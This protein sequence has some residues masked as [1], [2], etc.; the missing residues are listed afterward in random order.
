MS[1]FTEMFCSPGF[2][3]VLLM[4]SLRCSLSLSLSRLPVCLI[5]FLFLVVFVSVFINLINLML[6]ELQSSCCF[7]VN[8]LLVLVKVI[9]SALS[10]IYDH[11]L[12]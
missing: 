3:S 12:K 7:M 11:V 6:V 4:I 5:F 1:G 2:V 10:S 8:V 9:L